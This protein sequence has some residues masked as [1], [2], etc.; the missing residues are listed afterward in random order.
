MSAVAALPMTLWHIDRHGSGQWLVRFAAV[1]VFAG[2]IGQWFLPGYTPDRPR[3]L[4][5]H[6]RQAAGADTAWMVL[7]SHASGPDREYAARH[8]FREVEVPGLDDTAL[9]V[10]TEP[11]VLP[12]VEA[13]ARRVGEGERGERSR[14]FIVDLGLPEGLRLLALSA[15]GETEL[16]HASVD[17]QLVF[18]AALPAHRPGAPRQIVLHAPPAGAARIEMEFNLG[19][20]VEPAMFLD[21]RFE[22]PDERLAPFSAGW[23]DDAHPAFLGPRAIVRYR[24]SLAT[25]P[26]GGGSSQPN[27]QDSGQVSDQ[28]STR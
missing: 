5:V 9:A 26:A 8:D 28:A 19:A 1:L 15:P 10:A 14:R 18:D 20:G 7:E 22:L 23:P 4:T 25:A 16:L 2:C 21:A 17:G 11:L 27:A 6:Y 13:R 24:V 3:D 12:T